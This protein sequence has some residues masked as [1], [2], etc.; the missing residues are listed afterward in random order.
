MGVL[1]LPATLGMAVAQVNIFVS[2]ILASY[3]PQGSITYLY[4]SMRLIQ[5][6]IGIFGVAMGMAV[7][8]A[9]SEHAARGET[10]R[11][12]EDFS[13]ALRLLFFITVPAMA[14]LIALRGPIVNLLF[15]RGRF[16]A[17]GRRGD[18][19][20]AALLR[21]RH[22]GRGRRPGGHGRPSTRC[23]TRGRRCGSAWRRCW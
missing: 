9:L 20:G 12:R 19:P 4:Y 15:V 14:G 5:F 17:G 8:P 10:D 23:R 11:L 22:L 2:N 1:L 6:P 3:L 13:Y 21:V 16:D 18:G 7:L